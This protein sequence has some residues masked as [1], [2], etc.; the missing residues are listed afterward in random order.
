MS[1]SP[2]R[3]NL[4]SRQGG[5][6]CAWA[7]PTGAPLPSVRR[8]IAPGGSAALSW[9][10]S[11]HPPGRMNSPHGMDRL[12]A[13]LRDRYHL[14]H[15]LGEG[16]M[17]TVFLAEDLKHDRQVAIKVLKPELAAVI[18]GERFVTEIKTTA[19]LQHPH[20]LPL[21]DSGAADGFLYYVMP[22][23]D[24]ESLRD[25]LDREKQLSIEESVRIAG[26]VASA[27]HYAHEQGIVHR[28]IKPAN[29]LLHAGEPVVADFGIALAISAAGGGRLTETGMSVGTPHY[30]SPEQASADRVVSARS[31]IYALACVLYEML[32]GDPPHTGPTAQS[33]LMRILTE[34]PRDVGTVRKAVPPHVRDAVMKALEK[35]PADRFASAGEFKRALTDEGF[36]Y[37]REPR[38]SGPVG[39]RPG[40]PAGSWSRDA[41]TRSLLAATVVLAVAL[42]AAGVQLSRPGPP[43]AIAPAHRYAILDT[44]R[45]DLIFNVSR[46]GDVVYAATVEGR[47][48]L[49]LRRATDT[50][51]I[52]IPNTTDGTFPAFSPAGDW[53]AFTV[54]QRELKKVQLATGT[55][56][57]VV[58]EGTAQRIAFVDWSSDRTILFAAADGVYRVP[59]VGGDPELIAAVVNPIFPR[60]LPGG[61]ALLY[62]EMPAGN[63]ASARV[64]AMSLATGDTVTVA[65]SGGN[66][67]WS[68]T[69]HLVFGHRS[70]SIFAV[71]FDGRRGR[72]T[73]APVPVQENVYTIGA[74]SFFALSE[75][76]SL[77]Y[78]GGAGGSI[79]VS[80]MRFGWLE[81]DGATAPIPLDPTDHTDAR[82]SPDGRHIVYT[83][84]GFLYVFDLDRG[85]NQ[86]LTF[87]GDNYHD[88][89]WSPDGRRIAFTAD[90]PDGRGPGDVYVK[91]VDGR[92][93]AEW[94]VG[95]EGQQYPTEWLEDGTLVLFSR[96][97]M[98]AQT[99]VYMARMGSD[100]GPV[101]LLRADWDES[102]PRVSPDRR[103]MAYTSEETGERH[104]FVREF[105]GM[106][107]RWQ[108][109]ARPAW[110]PL[111]WAPDGRAIFYQDQE[112]NRVIR[113]DL[114]HEPTLRVVNRTELSTEPVL[115]LRDIHPDG[116]R[117]LVTH[118]AGAAP[119]GEAEVQLLVVANWFTELRNRL[120]GRN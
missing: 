120:G 81:M 85:T 53:V 54:R 71:P 66:A 7:V 34:E 35:L 59:E 33:V 80:D 22:Y 114:E 62:T 2:N 20:I 49:R 78:L 68:P 56:V 44:A 21:F 91:D 31:D 69:G 72:V 55:A 51:S 4:S 94:V 87:E 73:G 65:P 37:L 107:G 43:G 92:S 112:S 96:E 105:P 32:T 84:G 41:R 101:P 23:V 104:V 1:T 28:D 67:F 110:G 106:T 6:T 61:G 109:S 64:V 8:Y 93:R 26:A 70:A 77:A 82:V 79:D 10:Y 25:K 102:S 63:P 17:A 38:S 60:L 45:S 58:P 48:H 89:V 116:Q 115:T 3:T 57:T 99:D 36:S 9:A 83:R 117:L 47:Q 52:E 18:G 86:R 11:S 42:V 108:V 5:S 24:G 75:S 16:G 76:G 30:M 27:L 88:P 119:P 12:N 14:L 90:R 111:V 29:I 113:A 103:L 19:A 40:P 98:G 74:I 13:A 50:R 95:F 46:H 39:R 15:Q 100:D 97:Q 118:A